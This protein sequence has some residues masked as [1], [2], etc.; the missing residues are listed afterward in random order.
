MFE[1]EAWVRARSWLFHRG[2]PQI[3]GKVTSG[4]ESDG[5]KTVSMGFEGRFGNFPCFGF[6]VSS[7]DADWASLDVL[8]VRL[9]GAVFPQLTI[10]P[11]LDF[12]EGSR[13]EISDDFDLEWQAVCDSSDFA[14]DVIT[15][16]L[17]NQIKNADFFRLWFEGDSLLVSVRRELTAG[18]I[19]LYLTLL[20]R[21]MEAIP[22]EV[23]KKVVIPRPAT[24]PMIGAGQGFRPG[25]G[26]PVRPRG[27]ASGMVWRSWAQ[28]R[29]WIYTGGV[30]IHARMRFRMPVRPDPRGFVGKFGDLPVFGFNVMPMRN[31]LGVRVAGHQMPVIT[32][33]RDN[34]VL[35]HMI[36]SSGVQVGDQTFD[37]S[38]QVD[39]TEP[40]RA[41]AVLTPAVRQQLERGPAFDR[42][43]FAH[44]TL[45]LLTVRTIVPDEVD[46]LLTWLLGVAKELPELAP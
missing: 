43:W 30:E 18:E 23:V 42:M 19:D 8:A 41:R 35:S 28:S 1:W 34:N 37:D 3:L 9:S 14:H 26:F 44:D 22:G 25:A 2:W 11:V 24:R 17:I 6:R 36:G 33:R 16:Q 45:A 10:A 29:Q 13:V 21:I 40:Q 27:E 20:H 32:L 4:L 15:A 5:E 12:L 7:T 31:V 38:W 46:P 39:S